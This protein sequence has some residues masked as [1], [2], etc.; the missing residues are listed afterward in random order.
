MSRNGQPDRLTEAKRLRAEGLTYREIGERVGVHLATVHRWLNPASREVSRRYQADP[1]NHPKCERCG[2]PMWDQ[3]HGTSAGGNTCGA[4]RSRARHLRGKQIE[5]QW[6][7]GWTTSE[8]A[9]WL[10]WTHTYVTVEVAHL[11]RAGYD[12]PHRR[13]PEQVE[14]IRAGWARVRA[15]A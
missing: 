5:R 1:A 7:E 14:R 11:R 15:K 3:R 10:G 12:L 2:E 6:A 8:I 9:D 13:S 4:C